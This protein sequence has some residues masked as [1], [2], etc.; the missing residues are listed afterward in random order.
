[1]RK[2]ALALTVSIALAGCQPTAYNLLLPMEPTQASIDARRRVLTDGEKDMIS[3]AVKQKS[4]ELE[5]GQFVWPPLIVRP[6]DH[7]IDYC[8]LAQPSGSTT[9]QHIFYTYRAELNLDGG[10]KISSADVKSVAE[11]NNGKLPTESDSICV[12]DG[13]KILPP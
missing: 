2:N 9:R 8:G 12:Q 5:Y 4:K 3:D 10:G 1:M 13:Y 11:T 6:H 7:V